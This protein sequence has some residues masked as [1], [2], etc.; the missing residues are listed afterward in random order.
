MPFRFYHP[1]ILKLLSDAVL[2]RFWFRRRHSDT[3]RADAHRSSFFAQVWRDAAARLGATV[4]QLDQDLLEIRLGRAHTRV[5]E[6]TTAIDDPVT[7]AVAINKPL[8]DRL[9]AK[10]GLRTPRHVEFTLSDID[11][12]VAFIKRFGGEWVVKPANGAM[13]RGVTTGVI[14]KFDLVRAAVTAAAYDA[15]FLV[16]QQVQGDLY[17]LLYLN[18]KLLDAV[19][20]KSPTVVADGRSSV[21]K[22]VR[23][24]NRA[25]LEAGRPFGQVL[26]SIDLDMRNTLAKQGLSLSSVPKKGTVI[27]LK[28]VI[29]E[30]SV[31]D[32]I[33]ATSLLCPSI[34][35]DGAAAAAAVG[36]RLA[37]VDIVTRDPGVPLAQSG[38][39]ILEVNTTP[40][41]AYH[42]HQ[43]NGGVAVAIP[44]LSWLLRERPK[45][46]EV[47]LGSRGV[48]PLDAVMRTEQQ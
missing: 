2:A 24:E 15:H 18:G 9:L 40:G 34:I 25:R 6:N 13:G 4:E 19:L 41:Y 35:E 39:V 32:N 29:N 20:R 28:T 22:L 47:L 17:R 37:G 44:I 42:Y 1:R 30:N 14:T 3:R 48:Q 27:T 7:L 33:S 16:E 10:R 23:V 46:G 31:A 38:G 21:R 11:Q 36:A 8:V 12:A 5:R 45:E 43:R 26:V